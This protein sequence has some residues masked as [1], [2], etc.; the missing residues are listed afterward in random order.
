MAFFVEHDL[1][2]VEWPVCLLEFNRLFDRA[3]DGG[4]FGVLLEDPDVLDS[5]RM[6]VENSSGRVEQIE[7]ADNR[8]RVRICKCGDSE[9]GM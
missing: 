4:V 1:R 2:E 7:S 6:I 3:P 8:Y 5:I 9:A